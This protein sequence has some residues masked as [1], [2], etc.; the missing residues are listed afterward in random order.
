MAQFIR[1]LSILIGLVANLIPLYGVLVWQWDTFQLLMLY[2]METVIVAF[3]TIRRLARIPEDQL[4]SMTVNAQ[5]RTATR[6]GLTGFFTLHAG[7]FI[8]VHLVFL[9]VLFSGDWFRSIP[10]G[11]GV[12]SALFL[13]NGVWLALLIMFVA[14]W[15]SYRVNTEPSY[16]RKLERGLYPKRVV[17]PEAE[18]RA[19][20]AVGNVIGG[21][22]VRI[23]IMQ[24]A[25]IAGGFFAQSY[26]SIVPLL[27]VIGFKTL[28]DLGAA[29]WGWKATGFTVSSDNTSIRT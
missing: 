14:G 29:W 21:L 25:I 6:A 24:V 23:V 27:I 12:L 22:Y 17:P 3:W 18:P 20:D 8:F 11:Q 26:G 13:T 10:A 5:V 28:F 1:T 9:L 4:G 16:P 2:W 7:M 19:G 15:I